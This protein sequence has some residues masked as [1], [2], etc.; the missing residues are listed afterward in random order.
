[1]RHDPAI[2]SSLAAYSHPIVSGR[3]AVDP[4][5][6]DPKIVAI[7]AD[8]LGI[9]VLGQPTTPGTLRRRGVQWRDHLRLALLQLT[10]GHMPFVPFYEV[11][12]G[13]AYLAGLPERMPASLLSINTTP[14]GDLDYVEQEAAPDAKAT[15]RLV[16][17]PAASMLWYAHDRE[18]AAWQGRSILRASFGPWLFKQD[19]MRVSATAQRRFGT[20]VPVAVPLLGTSP[21]QAEINAA[22]M[23]ASQVRVGDEA[24]AAMPPGFRLELVGASGS[25]PDGLPLLRYYDEQMARSMLASVLDLGS[26]SN[27]SRALGTSFLDVLG[28]ALQGIADTL[29]ETATQ[30]C[31]RLTDFNAG[32]DAP[33]PAVVVGDVAG[34]EQA[35][36]VTVGRLLTEGA[37]SGDPDLEAWVRETFRLPQ[38]PPDAASGVAARRR[39]VAETIQK[40]Y[41]GVGTI[42]SPDEAR[43]I[44]NDAGADLKIPGPD[45]LG[46]RPGTVRAANERAGTATQDSGWPYPR[47]LSTVEA[48]AG[49]DP[50]AVDVAADAILGD[51]MRAWP[52]VSAGWRDQLR[53]A[54]AAAVD[55]G[56]LAGLAGLAVDTTDGA[57]IIAVAMVEAAAAGADLAAQEA[58]RQGVDLPLAEVDGDRLAVLAA[59]LAA[60]MGASISAA[61]AREALRL[62]SSGASGA[63][64]GEAVWEFLAGLSDTYPGDVL[65]GAVNGGVNAGRGAAFAAGPAGATFSASEI[66]DGNTCPACA[67]NDGTVYPDLP[68]AEADFPTGGY[69][70]CLGR[71]RCRGIILAEWPTP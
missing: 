68:A 28:M 45:G 34:S 70:L 53:D 59:A 30:L 41:L 5:G 57:E 11:R 60:V 40:T 46:P 23:M 6:A 32:P 52:Q 14:A 17:I 48:R 21:T 8:S 16:K 20:P 24:G 36:A 15:N 31:V 18:G 61:A 44:V 42:I 69:A 4:R 10:F 22:Q 71:E 9:P 12:A 47:P 19:Q 54:V 37:L 38:K 50:E 43:A 51:L 65:A 2:T 29:A 56:D 67:A 63:T 39:D 62:A 55:S 26:T 25:V 13:A 33:S 66:R 7:C 27:G 49:L 1:M 64:V 35:L 3:W 58:G